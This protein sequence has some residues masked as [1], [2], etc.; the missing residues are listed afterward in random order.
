MLIKVDVIVRVPVV[1]IKETAL[2]AA[3]EQLNRSLKSLKGMLTLH[4]TPPMNSAEPKLA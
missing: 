4:C 1:Q 2:R 3:R